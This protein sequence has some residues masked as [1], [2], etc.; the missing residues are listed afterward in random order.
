VTGECATLNSNHIPDGTI[1]NIEVHR[2]ETIEKVRQ[3]FVVLVELVDHCLVDSYDSGHGKMFLLL[4][5]GCQVL[6]ALLISPS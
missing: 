1:D 2:A 4:L 3:V 5:G 6:P